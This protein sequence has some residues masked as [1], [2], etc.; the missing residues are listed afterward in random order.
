[1]NIIH[2]FIADAKSVENG[3]TAAF[4]AMLLAAAYPQ[5]QYLLT[6][7]FFFSPIKRRLIMLT[8]NKNPKFSYL[9]RIVVLP[10]LVVVVLLF[11]FR[12]KHEEKIKVEKQNNKNIVSVAKDTLPKNV[13]FILDGKRV[14]STILSKINPQQIE[15]INVLKDSSAFA[16]YGDE[17]KNGV[18]EI[19]TKSGALKNEQGKI[20]IEVDSVN[21]KLNQKRE[22]ANNKITDSILIVDAKTGKLLKKSTKELNI[23][24]QENSGS[25]SALIINPAFSQFNKSK[26]DTLKLVRV[27]PPANEDS[28]VV[29]ENTGKIVKI[30]ANGL[31]IKSIPT[32]KSS[33]TITSIGFISQTDTKNLKLPDD[34][35]D[36]L[37]RNKEVKKVMWGSKLD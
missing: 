4:A 13:L 1:M 27:T 37:N 6:N 23:N 30:K 11:A 17:G 24:T 19:I 12:V 14:D 10:L 3:D 7:S 15:S 9:R 32:K 22:E 34:Y 35:K 16:K 29:I 36:F 5:Q 26:S 18:V 31:P 21:K 2:E 20:E 28:V 25:D 8:Q 33:D